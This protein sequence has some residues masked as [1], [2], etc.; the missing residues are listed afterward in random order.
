MKAVLELP[1][2]SEADTEKQ[3]KKV[4][5]EYC[6][7]FSFSLFS[8][9]SLVVASSPPKLVGRR[10]GETFRWTAAQHRT[11][12]HSSGD[13]NNTTTKRWERGRRRRNRGRAAGAE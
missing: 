1:L 13:E 12:K 3:R 10:H 5:L 7:L 8:F 4:P 6:L 9:L 11:K 2:S